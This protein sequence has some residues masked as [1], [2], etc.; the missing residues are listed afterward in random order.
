M[1]KLLEILENIY[2]KILQEKKN[3]ISRT[4]YINL[5]TWGKDA[6]GETFDQF[7]ALVYKLYGKD[8]IPPHIYQAMSQTKTVGEFLKIMKEYNAP[9]LKPIKLMYFLSDS[10]KSI[11]VKSFETWEAAKNSAKYMSPSFETYENDNIEFLQ[12]VHTEL[13]QMRIYRVTSYFLKHIATPTMF[14]S[15]D[16]SISYTNWK[17]QANTALRQKGTLWWE[18]STF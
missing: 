15:I 12:I 11:Q 14:K 5:W 17:K 6:T 2:L 4:D 13:K 18:Y 3:K 1:M 8:N 9:V 7:T 16:S 10:N